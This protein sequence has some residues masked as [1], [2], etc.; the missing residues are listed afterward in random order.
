MCREMSSYL[1]ELIHRGRV[2]KDCR[3]NSEVVLSAMEFVKLQICY[4]GNMALRSSLLFA[5]FGSL[6]ISAMP[7]LIGYENGNT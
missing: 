4:F 6:I 5:A 1:L 2:D 3:S 7:A